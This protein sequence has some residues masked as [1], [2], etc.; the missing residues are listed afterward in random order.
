MYIVHL[1]RL[2]SLFRAQV[3]HLIALGEREGKQNEAAEQAE[4]LLQKLQ[5][6]EAEVELHKNEANALKDAHLAAKDE[7]A[8][9]KLI[10][11]TT[12]ELH[13]EAEATTED[14]R[15][16]LKEKTEEHLSVVAEHEKKKDQTEQLLQKLQEKEAEVD[17]L[18]AD[19]ERLEN[20]LSEANAALT[21][22]KEHVGSDAGS[23]A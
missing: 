17:R 18:L 10:K 20:E 16:Q 11:K 6:K 5:E 21:V 22:Y 9:M 15:K 3:E 8:G 4:R 13:K 19:V 14:L 1:H 2:D 23:D 7:I 12:Q